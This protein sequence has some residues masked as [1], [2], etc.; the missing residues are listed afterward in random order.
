MERRKIRDVEEAMA[1]LD[2]VAQS[3]LTRAQWAHEHGIDARSLNAWRLNLSRKDPSPSPIRVVE[4]I[5][6]ARMSPRTR[7][8]QVRCGPFSIDVPEDFDAEHLCDVLTV[9]ASC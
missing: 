8:L 2:A 6:D 4:L 5:P 7:P 3:G 9:L 1:C